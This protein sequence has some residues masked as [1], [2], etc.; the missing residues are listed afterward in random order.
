MNNIAAEAKLCFHLSPLLAFSLHFSSSS[1]FLRS[2]FTQSSHLSCGLPLF[3][4]PSC[5]FFL[6]S[7][8]FHSDSV[9]SQFLPALDYFPN[10][11]SFSSALTNTT[12]LITT[13]WISPGLLKRVRAVA[14]PWSPCG[15]TPRSRATAPWSSH[16]SAWTARVTGVDSTCCGEA[17]PHVRSALI[18]NTRPSRAN[19]AEACNEYSTTIPSKNCKFTLINSNIQLRF[20]YSF[21]FNTWYWPLFLLAYL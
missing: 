2:L 19:A 5:I 4:Q 17:V 3:L 20:M 21:D 9:S 14:Q 1:A 15:A 12:D 10:Y 13:L 18:T 11:T 6:R 16:P 8:V 7:F